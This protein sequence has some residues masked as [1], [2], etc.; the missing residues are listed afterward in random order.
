MG[1]LGK[2]SPHRCHQQQGKHSNRK[3]G[4]CWD[5][6]TCS[7]LTTRERYAAS[8]SCARARRHQWKEVISCRPI[9][10]LTYNRRFNTIF[11]DDYFYCKLLP[12]FSFPYE[13]LM[14]QTH[15]ATSKWELYFCEVAICEIGTAL[16]AQVR[17]YNLCESISFLMERTSCS[18]E[19]Q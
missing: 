16:A 8:Q 17:N 15:Q 18:P 12:V 4:L 9:A 1:R 5:A 14:R 10:C 13:V 3:A 19:M 2:D 6:P 7:R 11:L